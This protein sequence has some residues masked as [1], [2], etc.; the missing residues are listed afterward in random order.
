MN[1]YIMFAGGFLGGLIAGFYLGAKKERLKCEID[2]ESIRHTYRKMMAEYEENTKNAQK[3][4]AEAKEDRYYFEE[5]LRRLG[6]TGSEDRT[7]IHTEAPP[8]EKEPIT[9]EPYFSE[10]ETLDPQQLELPSEAEIRRM[11]EQRRKPPEVIS[12]EVFAEDFSKEYAKQPLLWYP[13]DRIM[14][15][16]TTHELM[17]DPY[18]FLGLEWEREIDGNTVN[19]ID[20]EAYV[21]SDW[22]ETDYFILRQPGRGSDNMSLDISGD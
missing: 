11:D 6:Y 5:T 10:E 16:A 18:S 9:D 21:R 14:L 2:I 20:G 12:E 7:D 4:A 3:E 19:A 1:R 13:E 15:D 22:W 8:V 17:D